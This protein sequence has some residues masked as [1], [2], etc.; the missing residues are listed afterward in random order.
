VPDST[1]DDILRR[2]GL[3][4][5]ETRMLDAAQDVSLVKWVRR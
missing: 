1:A 4:V 3:A 5:D 2:H